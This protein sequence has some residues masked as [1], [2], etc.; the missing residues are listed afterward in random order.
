MTRRRE[1]EEQLRSLTEINEIMGSMKNLSIMETRKLARVLPAQQ[2]VVATFERAAADFLAYHQQLARWPAPELTLFV[3]I[4]SER[5]FCGDFN[6]KLI[7]RLEQDTPGTAPGAVRWLPVGRKLCLSL[8]REARV[9][10]LLDGPG[11]VEEVPDALSRLV[12]AIN[13]V[14]Q[15]ADTVELRVLHHS[16]EHGDVAQTP[17]LPPF[18]GAAAPA[19]GGMQPVVSGQQA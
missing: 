8:E 3:V 18:R 1:V 7:E 6:E 13:A 12:D 10:D 15:T 19:R 16:D 5:G 2:Q 17:V 9:A 11:V 4:G 14:R